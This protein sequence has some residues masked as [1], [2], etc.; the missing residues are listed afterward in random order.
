[1]TSNFTTD[2]E[3]GLPSTA[4][5]PPSPPAGGQSGAKHCA[6]TPSGYSSR[7]PSVVSSNPACSPSRHDE[8]P[9]PDVSAYS[10]VVFPTSQQTLALRGSVTPPSTQP[11]SGLPSP[12]SRSDTVASAGLQTVTPLPA[13]HDTLG[14]VLERAIAR[15]KAAEGSRPFGSRPRPG[16]MV[17]GGRPPAPKSALLTNED[18]IDLTNDTDDEVVPSSEAGEELLFE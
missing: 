15:A 11:R 4:P 18:I 10:P 17:P 5:G 14:E 8:D 13:E 2:D 6:S 3:G 7:S 1:M 16:H 12:T 9:L